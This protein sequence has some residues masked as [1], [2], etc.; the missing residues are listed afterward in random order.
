MEMTNLTEYASNKSLEDLHC[1]SELT[2]EIHNQLIFLSVINSFL[3]ITAFLGNTLILVALHKESSL[4]PPSKLLLRS[5]TTT[6]LCVGIITQPLRVTYFASLL[7]KRWDI[8]RNTF[9]ILTIM[10]FILSSVS[11]FTLAAISVDR[12]LALSLGI[13]YRQVVTLKRISLTVSLS[14]VCSAISSTLYFWSRRI[15]ALYSY[16]VI[17]LCII[18]SIVSYTKIFLALRQLQQRV[19]QEQ[20]GQTVPLNITRYK[21]TVTSALW[22][23]LALVACYLPFVIVGIFN[24][25]KSQSP[26]VL[27]ARFY[28]ITL[29]LLNSSLNPILYCWKIKEVKQA[30]KDTIRELFSYLFNC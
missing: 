28:S 13:R 10:G 7:I 24:H 12:L 27:V 22:V 18:T 8:C 14:W 2:G 20:P 25:R 6:D 21:K 9:A 11:L 1:S 26:S 4:H 16:T 15:F 17:S 29:V 3:S 5:L 23:Q 30:V 19:N